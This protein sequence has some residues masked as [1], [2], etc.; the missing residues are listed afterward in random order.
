M[1]IGLAV[2][3]NS[4]QSVHNVLAWKSSLPTH[5][6]THYSIDLIHAWVYSQAMKQQSW[7]CVY[8]LTR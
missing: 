6:H 1:P 5:T 4:I 3:L 2:V 7:H 8:N